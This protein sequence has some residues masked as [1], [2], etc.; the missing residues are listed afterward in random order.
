[1]GILNFF[2]KDT[3]SIAEQS[4]T[5]AGPMFEEE[6]IDYMDHF[7]RQTNNR[8]LSET[9]N[10]NLKS[11][12]NEN[13]VILAKEIL[14]VTFN[15]I[16]GCSTEPEVED[17]YLIDIRERFYRAVMWH[18]SDAVHNIP[19]N[20]DV[21]RAHIHLI[22]YITQFFV[23]VECLERLENRPQFTYKHAPE[24]LLFS[25]YTELRSSQIQHK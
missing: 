10:K 14:S 23:F 1:M 24:Y 21:E 12:S 11:M 5:S 2:K 25:F 4:L 17:A 13:L 6:Y 9:I 3:K 18:L 20:L 22:D 7:F 16:R 19:S 15:F 8:E